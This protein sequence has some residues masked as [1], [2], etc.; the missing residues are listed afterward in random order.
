MLKTFSSIDCASNPASLYIESGLSWSINLSGSN[1]DLNLRPLSNKFFSDKK[2]D[3]CEAK[4][5]IEPSS[6][7]IIASWSVA[8][9]H[10][11]F[12]SSGFANLASAIE[13]LIPFFFK[14]IDAF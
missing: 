1:I 5:P 4:P 10:I 8:N 7:V 11:N 3:T 2:C 12:S 14:A 6:I 13:I 9:C